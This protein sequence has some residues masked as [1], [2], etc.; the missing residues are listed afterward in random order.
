V[1]R[2][3][4]FLAFGFIVARPAWA[5]TAYEIPEGD[6]FNWQITGGGKGQMEWQA[7]TPHGWN[8]PPVL[9]PAGD[10]LASTSGS[11]GP[12][13]VIPPTEKNPLWTIS[14][15]YSYPHPP[16]Y[17]NSITVTATRNPPGYY[18]RCEYYSETYQ[19]VCVR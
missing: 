8:L 18:D 5:D 6:N 12:V 9:L 2:A 4:S 3:A 13:T 15:V 1:I 17:P 11:R 16:N 19:V 14:V 7:L 10:I